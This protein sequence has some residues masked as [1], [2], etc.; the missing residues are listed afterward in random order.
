MFS[1]AQAG[2]G[3]KMQ[4]AKIPLLIKR[5]EGFTLNEI[6]VSIA[7]IAIGVLGF[8]VNT[9][10]VIQGNQISGNVTI[11]TELAQDKMEEIKA[12]GNLSN[13]SD[14]NITAT[15][16]SGGTFNR[17]W[18]IGTSSLNDATGGAAGSSLKEIT[19]TVSWTEYQVT[20]EV[21]VAALLFQDA[22]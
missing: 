16:A 2:Y 7:L 1:A 13:G 19:V 9:I 8:S 14:D 18:T 20:R 6:L 12:T 5:Q 17:A 3:L 4:R 10:G 15:G 21:K 11:A 22:T